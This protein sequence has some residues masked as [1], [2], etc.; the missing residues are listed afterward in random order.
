MR[1]FEPPGERGTINDPYMINPKGARIMV[2]AKMV[3][4]LLS[5]GFILEDRDWKQVF[6]EEKK[7]DPLRN[8]P[9]S[10][11]KILEETQKK[12]DTLD[13]WEV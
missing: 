4:E 8:Y 7:E 12:V 10:R 2:P 5:K 11:S 9:M 6:V 3:P 13:V 1:L